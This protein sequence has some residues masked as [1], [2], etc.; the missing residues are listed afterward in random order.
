MVKRGK[1]MRLPVISVSGEP[2]E[3][4]FQ[5]GSQ[6]KAAV[7]HNVRFYLD[8][9]NYFSGVKRDQVIEDARVFI[10]YIK[11]LD[12]QLLEE[13]RGVAE[14]SEAH[15]EE[16]IALNCRWELNYAYMPSPSAWAPP[17]GCTAFALT[18]EATRNQHAFV[19]QHWD[20]KPAL[21]KSCVILRI[22]R[23]KKPDI[24]MHTEAGI[25]GHKGFN[26][27]GIGVCLNYIR[28]DKDAF[29]PG[30]PLW[31]KI[32]KI[33]DSESLPECMG[34]IM[35]FQQPNSA[36][37]VIAHR[38]GEAIDAECT[39][40]D[41]FFLYPEHGILTHTNHFQSPRLKER[42][43][44]KALVPDTVIRSHR[45]TR[46]F[47]DRRGDLVFDSI[48]DVLKDHFGH[49][50]S[51]CR[52][53]DERLHPNEQWETLTSMIIDL[54]EDKMLYTAGPPCSYPYETV[55]MDENV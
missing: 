55:A 31:I 45:A 52:H 32:R 49:P 3:L 14:G 51:I 30:F 20:Y 17:E 33:L 47:H 2:Y 42:D 39:P 22:N 6:T 41:T 54:T 7:E 26:S 16:I 19:G 46:L 43:T 50:E 18:P 24:I 10:P 5:H 15:F 44:G 53:R 29:R 13:L 25:I 8:L 1:D 21:E 12:A 27:A 23:E 38:D 40:T 11:K 4:G 35:T 36:N 48:K 9:W 34:I 28:C 37:M